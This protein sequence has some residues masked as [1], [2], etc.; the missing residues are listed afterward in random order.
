MGAR[1]DTIPALTRRE[2]AVAAS[3][4]R[5]PRVPRSQLWGPALAAFNADLGCRL[6]RQVLR[7]PEDFCE[8]E[9]ENR[10]ELRNGAEETVMNYGS[11]HISSAKKWAA[12]KC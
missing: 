8:L 12:M 11:E 10:G 6:L 4:S 2:E 5:L 9:N 3:T 1:L 7:P